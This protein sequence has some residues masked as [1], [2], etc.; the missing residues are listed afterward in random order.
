M[1]QHGVRVVAVG[2][3]A[4]LLLGGCSG[5]RVTGTWAGRSGESPLFER[6]SFASDRTFT[7]RIREGDTVHD[8]EGTWRARRN[9]LRIASATG[10]REYTFRVHYGSLV[11]TDPASGRTVTLDPAPR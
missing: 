11:V 9:Q 4:A 8:R 2:A 7:A 1:S 6:V 3:A 10:T 5:S